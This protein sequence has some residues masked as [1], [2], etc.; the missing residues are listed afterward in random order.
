MSRPFGVA[1]LIAGFFLN[2]FVI[3][4]PAFVYFSC[5]FW[6]FPTVHF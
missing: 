2:R 5:L 4:Q 1:L 6:V 3:N